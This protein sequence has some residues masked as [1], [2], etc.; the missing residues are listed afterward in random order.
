M[1]ILTPQPLTD[2]GPS[3][4][5]DEPA[6]PGGMPVRPSIGFGFGQRTRSGGIKDDF[7]GRT[8]FGPPGPGPG[9]RAKLRR[10]RTVLDGGSITPFLNTMTAA[11]TVTGVK[12]D[13]GAASTLTTGTFTSTTGQF[14]FVMGTVFKG[15]PG[16]ATWHVTTPILDSKANAWTQVDV[17]HVT[18]VNNNER[19]RLYYAFLTNAGA[20][21]TISIQSS[22]N[23]QML[24][25]ANLFTGVSTTSTVDVLS[26]QE[27]IA[28]TTDFRT[29]P[30]ATTNAADLLVL[31]QSNDN[32]FSN[33]IAAPADFTKGSSVEGG[34]WFGGALA[35]SLKTIPWTYQPAW[36]NTRPDTGW[37]GVVAFR[38]ADAA[39]VTN[40]ATVSGGAL[41]AST[42]PVLKEKIGAVSGGALFASSAALSVIRIGKLLGGGALFASAATILKEKLG[43]VSGGALFASAAAVLKQKIGAV[44][45]GAL[46]AGAATTTNSA[47][48]I[49]LPTGGLA[50]ASA[51][52]I[53]K[54]KIGAVSGGLTCASAA[55]VEKNKIG[56]V[57][58]G[59]TLAGAA[60]TDLDTLTTY[61]PTGGLAFSG[62]AVTE[63]PAAIA[64]IVTTTFIPTWRPRR[65]R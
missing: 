9:G 8:K 37:A 49:Y 41:F 44:T 6:A 31:W 52:E 16:N 62:S 13:A 2:V 51:A 40:T 57:S 10:A 64:G 63:G 65:F 47:T 30:I 20:S 58:G 26:F 21:H 35:W 36:F 53:L 27:F 61:L 15:S 60:T 43:A 7:K 28:A 34:G 23:A 18:S 19:V 38:Q 14:A 33:G 55:P 56:A 17:E 45:G 22:A 11:L 24:L 59:L 29:T 50:F 54:L 32:S 3:R 4:L 42:A 5:Q 48:F 25:L 1:P 46:F 12:E 39:A